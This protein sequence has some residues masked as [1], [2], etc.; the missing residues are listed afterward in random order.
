MQFG[1]VPVEIFGHGTLEINCVTKTLG[2]RVMIPSKL[3][4]FNDYD[5]GHDYQDQP[6]LG[7]FD[8]PN[9]YRYNIL[10]IS[11]FFKIFL[12]IS[13]FSRMSLSI[14]I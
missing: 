11:K 13:I 6:W 3:C 14:S 4:L 12:S 5:Y 1:I 2:P 7:V 8:I 9:P 10:L